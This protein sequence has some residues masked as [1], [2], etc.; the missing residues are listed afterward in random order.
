MGQKV[1]NPCDER[2]PQQMRKSSD[3]D[4]KLLHK[5]KKVEREKVAER[6]LVRVNYKG[7]VVYTTHPEDYDESVRDNTR[8]TR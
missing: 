4:A 8:V 3:E 2:K 5:L 6:K 1:L 7:A